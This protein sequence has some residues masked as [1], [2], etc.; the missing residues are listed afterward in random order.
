MIKVLIYFVVFVYKTV[1]QDESG[2]RAKAQGGTYEMTKERAQLLENIGME[3][4]YHPKSSA[5][6][7]H[8][9]VE[10]PINDGGN[11]AT[12]CANNDRIGNSSNN[13]SIAMGSEHGNY[14]FNLLRLAR[15]ETGGSV[16]DSNRPPSS[17]SDLSPSSSPLSLLPS[18]STIGKTNSASTTPKVAAT[19]QISSPVPIPVSLPSTYAEN[20]EWIAFY[21]D[22]RHFQAKYGHALIPLTYPRNPSLSQWVAEQIR[23]YKLF[24]K[25]RPTKMTDVHVQLLEGV[26][27][28]LNDSE[29]C[30][31]KH[32]FQELQLFYS[33]FGHYEINP[34]I[35]MGS[36]ELEKWAQ[37]QVL[38]M[39]LLEEGKPSY[40]SEKRMKMLESIGF[41]W[42][43]KVAV[44]LEHD[45]SQSKENNLNSDN[46]KQESLISFTSELSSSDYETKSPCYDRIAKRS[47]IGSCGI[48]GSALESSRISLALPDRATIESNSETT[49][50]QNMEL[51]VKLP[52]EAPLDSSKFFVSAIESTRGGCGNARNLSLVDTN[53]TKIE[54]IRDFLDHLQWQDIMSK[55]FL[56][57]S[58][59]LENRNATHRLLELLHARHQGASNAP[60]TH[61][62]QQQQRQQSM[63]N[64][65]LSGIKFDSSV[66]NNVKV[67]STEI[68]RN[69]LSLDNES[70]PDD[71]RRNRFANSMGINNMTNLHYEHNHTVKNSNTESCLNN[72]NF[73]AS[74]KGRLNA[75]Q[76]NQAYSN[77]C[78]ILCSNTS[79]EHLIAQ[80]AHH[81]QCEMMTKN[82]CCNGN[83]SS[84]KFSSAP[85]A[86]FNGSMR[87]QNQDQSAQ[88]RHQ[89][90]GHQSNAHFGGHRFFDNNY[91][92]KLLLSTLQNQNSK[93]NA[94]NME[95]A[96]VSQR[97]SIQ[98]QT[99][100]IQAIEAQLQL[101]NNSVTLNS[102]FNLIGGSQLQREFQ[103][104]PASPQSNEQIKPALSDIFQFGTI[105]IVKNI[106][107]V[108]GVESSHQ[109]K[110]A[111][112]HG[113][114]FDNLKFAREKNQKPS[115]REESRSNADRDG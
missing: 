45:I 31:W 16:S 48:V 56:A 108:A 105:D 64:A 78:N 103:P 38:Q 14:A 27:L 53:D 34:R 58:N 4:N 83:E 41:N 3:W 8:V 81:H 72:I 111:S 89:F 21:M 113:S 55:P 26:G 93:E 84:S 7:K 40:L 87:A 95:P 74:S 28:D 75:K 99:A 61:D 107:A 102:D 30:K 51:D 70:S 42:C 24:M 19:N 112:I 114:T 37:K 5:V 90:P 44:D 1:E 2:G 13:A 49:N 101:Q 11:K 92:M 20:E 76:K 100:T 50:A 35:G 57:S 62:P 39:R 33:R 65:I 43:K 25:G 68:L 18:I 73:V 36:Q 91:F 82:N 109:M 115:S 63:A 46:R 71:D 32:M 85:H 59:V 66:A 22:L 88:L 17:T 79:D 110:A 80:F 6:F 60:S 98:Q 104:N 52:G 69:L 94:P 97:E 12:N 106:S 23:Q 15:T 77:S 10:N 29:G 67:D 54:V 9:I 96:R 47:K 86:S